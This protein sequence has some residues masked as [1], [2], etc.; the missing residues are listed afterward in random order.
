MRFRVGPCPVRADMNS[1][2]VLGC[3]AGSMQDCVLSPVASRVF[4]QIELCSLLIRM[5]KG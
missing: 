3:G 1:G 2:S 4:F 5:V